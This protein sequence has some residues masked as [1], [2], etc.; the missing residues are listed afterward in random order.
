MK[1]MAIKKEIRYKAV[2]VL[3]EGGH[4]KA[5]KDIFEN[6]PPSVVAAELGFN[7]I[8]MKKIVGDPSDLRIKDLKYLAKIFDCD[9]STLFSLKKSN[10]APK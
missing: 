8:R 5:W 1:F 2:K 3:I 9:E 4:I 10:K 7:N 6:I